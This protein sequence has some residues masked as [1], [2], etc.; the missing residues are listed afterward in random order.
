M[1]VQQAGVVSNYAYFP[2]V[3]DE[4][5]FGVSR[6]EVFDALA[7]NGIG[8]RKY[9]YPLTNTFACFHNKY[10]VDKTPVARHVAERVLTLPLYADLALQD[11]DRI[12]GIILELRQL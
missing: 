8:A 12:C 10:E 3:F 7:K 9:F 4:K 2:V 11:V 1:N 6:N 5:R